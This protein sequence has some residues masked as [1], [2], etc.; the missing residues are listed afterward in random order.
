M[1]RHPRVLRHLEHCGRCS[2]AQVQPLEWDGLPA[3]LWLIRLRC[4]NC[5]WT[6][7]G[8]YER[9]EVARYERIM[10]GGRDDLIAAI[11]RARREAMDEDVERFVR[12]LEQDQILPFDF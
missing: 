10:E 12:A 3:D 4:P 6:E 8:V 2:A 1:S 5:G 9:A 7:E 11:E